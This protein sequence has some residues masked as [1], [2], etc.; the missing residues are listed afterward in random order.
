[1]EK[2]EEFYFGDG[3]DSG[4]VVFNAFAAKHANLFTQECDAIE[5]E[6][7]LEYAYYLLNDC[8][9]FRHTQVYEE[10]QQLFESKIEGNT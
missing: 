3:A 1:M 2:I 5:S 9:Y 10:F 4:E 7:K 6:N 8:S